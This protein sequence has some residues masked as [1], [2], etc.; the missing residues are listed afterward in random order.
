MTLF[1]I[2]MA[3]N[4]FIIDNGLSLDFQHEQLVTELSVFKADDSV[5]AIEIY[6]I[7]QHAPNARDPSP[8]LHR[9]GTSNFTAHAINA[10]RD[11][12]DVHKNISSPPDSD[13]FRT[14][15]GTHSCP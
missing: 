3:L 13:N 5:D 4:P 15:G 9:T 10:L 6:Q 12:G 14:G 1:K 11:M 8:G 7:K 2:A